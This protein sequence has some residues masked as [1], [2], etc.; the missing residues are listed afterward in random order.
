VHAFRRSPRVLSRELS[1]WQGDRDVWSVGRPDGGRQGDIAIIGHGAAARLELREPLQAGTRMTVKMR[2]P[3][4]GTAGI[5]LSSG[6]PDLWAFEWVRGENASH[7]R[8]IAA[9]NTK[10]VPVPAAV[11]NYEWHE[12]EL[13]VYARHV[14]LYVDAELTDHTAWPEPITAF[15]PALTMDTRWVAQFKEFTVERAESAAAMAGNGTR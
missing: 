6:G 15:R 4:A 13:R 9:G 8:C 1:H 12:A 2:L 14:V 10:Q 7:Y 5:A 11:E 3:H